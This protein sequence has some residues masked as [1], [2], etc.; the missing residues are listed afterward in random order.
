MFAT[1]LPRFFEL[2]GLLAD[3]ASPSAYFQDF[4]NLL[5]KEPLV[6]KVFARWE[7]KLQFLDENAW[8]DQKAEA[9]PYLIVRDQRRGWQQLFNVLGQA[10]AYKHLKDAGWA[11]VRFIPR[12]HRRK[13]PDLEG[14]DDLGRILCEV[15]TISP[16]DAE[17]N[18]RREPKVRSV[19]RELNASF[20]RKFRSSIMEAKAQL[21]T[22]DPNSEARHLVYVRVCFDDWVGYYADDY[23][24]QIDQHL[25]DNPVLGIE[26]VVSAD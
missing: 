4:E 11:N 23:F 13:T 20:F 9:Q 26:V 24:R 21:E 16:S 22:Y 8:R 15:K 17:L 1:V 10:D 12:E 7:K 2:R 5:E 3:P 6:R 19:E 14:S 18:A 25:R